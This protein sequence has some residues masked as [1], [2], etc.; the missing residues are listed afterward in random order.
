MKVCVVG[1]ER[2][3]TSAI[4]NLLHLGSGWSLLD[5]YGPAGY[6]Y[7]A[8]Y[9]GGAELAPRLWWQLQRHKIVKMPGFAS[10]LPYL[11][12][13]FPRKFTAVYMLRDPR[14]NVAAML[15]RIRDV[16]FG[17]L[18]HLY[19]TVEWMGTPSRIP[20]EVSLL[21]WRW[22]RYLE[23]GMRYQ[24][25]GGD[26]QFISYEDFYEDKLTTITELATRL[27]IPFDTVKVR[28]RLD[29]QYR[30]TWSNTIRGAGRWKEDLS[31]EEI[32]IVEDIC[33]DLMEVWGFA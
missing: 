33:G 30:K 19:L 2:S 6:A 10:I 26:I 24:E 17:S 29:V 23:M 1:C 25:S 12:R 31:T 3:G 20:D 16:P 15:E 5:D 9:T 14:D 13:R 32:T 28:D 18:T 22:R 11:R 7:P 4:S 27:N 21:A 8:I